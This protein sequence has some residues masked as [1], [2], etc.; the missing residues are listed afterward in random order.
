VNDPL[1]D[2]KKTMPIMEYI[3]KISLLEK[4]VGHKT[5]YKILEPFNMK[6]IPNDIRWL[7]YSSAATKISNF[8][9]LQ[10]YSFFVMP[11]KKNDNV[12]GNIELEHGEK[13]VFIEISDNILQPEAILAIISHEISHKYLH[14]NSIWCGTTFS[15]LENEVLTDI[16]AVFLG[17]GKLMLN[18]RYYRKSYSHG[19]V[20]T[21]EEHQI[22]YLGKSQLAFV[23]CLVCAMRGI[24]SNEYKNRLNLN[25]LHALEACEKSYSYYFQR[26]DDYKIQN[27][28]KVT[29]K[30][31]QDILS[32]VNN[33]YKYLRYGY[34]E[35]VAS[36]LLTTHRIL[37]DISP[38]IG[39]QDDDEFDPCLRF[40]NK[41]KAEKEI[42]KMISQLDDVKLQALKYND[43]L[44]SIS[45]YIRTEQPKLYQKLLF[46][47]QWLT[48]ARNH[49]ISQ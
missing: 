47:L 42:Q 15:K 20:T 6:N 38:K 39:N 18:G 33:N 24:P 14:I 31:T 34:V 10:K 41:F 8:I 3:D 27:K 13:D 16:A 36:F 23:Y 30:N 19:R 1:D 45:R 17:L 43:R 46:S 28:L 4:C 5:H 40:L 12:A 26:H 49:K 21:T 44:K 9:G 37:S 32:E 2:M 35:A 7:E 25:S 29:L 11:C 48:K 22:G